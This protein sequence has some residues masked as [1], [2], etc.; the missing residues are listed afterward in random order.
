MEL[1]GTKVDTKDLHV[2]VIIG[3]HCKTAIHT[4]LNSGSVVGICSNIFGV[5]FPLKYVPAFTWFGP[6]GYMEYKLDK[7]LETVKA[8]MPR[9]GQELTEA[10]EILLRSVFSSFE[11]DRNKLI[12]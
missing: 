4:R 2:G 8:V 3:D 9:R 11:M 10:G 12:K 1:C 6:D 5:D 7:A